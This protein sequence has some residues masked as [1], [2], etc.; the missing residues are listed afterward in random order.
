MVNNIYTLASYY[1]K[2]FFG[3][4]KIAPL[5]IS[6]HTMIYGFGFAVAE[7]RVAKNLAEKGIRFLIISDNLQQVLLAKE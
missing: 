3:S 6:Q 5:N 1:G 2:E 4:G 7:R